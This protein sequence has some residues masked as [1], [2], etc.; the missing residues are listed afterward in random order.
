IR[1][2]SA[3][4]DA[5][6]ERTKDAI[7]RIQRTAKRDASVFY[8]RASPIEDVETTLGE[9]D[10]LVEYGLCEDE[11]LALVLRRG[12]ARI[13]RLGR[14]ADVTAACE[15]LDGADADTDPTATLDRLRSLLVSSLGLP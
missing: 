1:E 15:A 8:P 4:V 5:A 12:D 2:K 6:E 9:G 7:E 13:V 14:A 10:A 11:A 3:A